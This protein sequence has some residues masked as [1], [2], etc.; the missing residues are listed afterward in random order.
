MFNATYDKKYKFVDDG[1]IKGAWIVLK[2]NW[3]DVK[4]YLV[5]L[6][7]QPKPY[8]SLIDL[9]LLACRK[10]FYMYDLGKLGILPTRC[11]S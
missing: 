5:S 6:Q 8:K 11:P 9:A 7:T 1:H 3:G 4:Q 10:Y 2:E